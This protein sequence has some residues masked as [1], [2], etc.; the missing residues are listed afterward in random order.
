METMNIAIP[1]RLKDYVQRRVEQ[2]S[3][4]SVSEYVREL[5]R[6]DQ[7]TAAQ[8]AL[9]LE[10]IEGLNSGPGEPV[11]EATWK[12]IRE[13]AKSKRAGRKKN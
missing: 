6:R 5:I 8:A 7:Q 1:S 2:G 11:T 12:R 10:L 4:S 13:K 3:Y 9:E